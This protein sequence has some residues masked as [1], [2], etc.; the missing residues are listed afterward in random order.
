MTNDGSNVLIM[1]VICVWQIV[2]YMWRVCA[3]HRTV[4][5]PVQCSHTPQ[6][7]NMLPNTDH[8]HNKHI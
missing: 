4:L 3:L 6:V 1:C 8:A 2:L 7:Q 5:S